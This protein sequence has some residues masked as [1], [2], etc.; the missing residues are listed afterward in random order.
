[1]RIVVMLVVALA[2]TPHV[3]RAQSADVPALI[4]LVD[5]EPAD[6]DRSV[7]K[8]KRREAVKKLA[9]SKDR[10]AVPVLIKLAETETFD[11]VG[12]IAIEGLGTL[13]DPSA[14]PTLQKI[15]GDPSRDKG[16]RDLARKSLAKLGASSAPT[17]APAPTPTPTPTPTPAPESPTPAPTAETGLENNVSDTT[18]SKLIDSGAPTPPPTASQLPQLD[19]DILAAYDRVTFAAGNASVTYE[20]IPGGQHQLEAEGS[21]SALWQQRVEHEQ[22]AWGFDGSASLVGGV[23][24]PPGRADSRGVELNVGGDG[25]GRAYW[26]G[27]YGVGRVAVDFDTDYT[28]DIVANPANANDYKLTTTDADGQ[29]ALGVGYGRELDVS[30][31]IRVR[32]LSRALDANRALGKPIDA[33]TSKKLQLTWWSLR[34]ERSAYRALLATVAILREAGVLLGEPDAGLT[35]EILNV[36]RD[37]YLYQRMDGFDANVEFGEGYLR[38]PADIVNDGFENGRVEQLL[39]NVGYGIQLDDDKMQLVATGY[40]RDRLFAP[41]NQ[42]SPW[43]LGASATA[44]RFTYGEH[45]DQFGALDLTATAQYAGGD[46]P[47]PMN[48]TAFE[49]ALQLGFTYLINQASGLRL[50]AQ[51]T[52][53]DGIY[54]FGATF[55]ATYGLLDGV[56]SR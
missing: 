13:G 41:M 3:A 46:L 23:I 39:V 38:R 56:F 51:V 35:Y 43:A 50:A 12:E 1:M 30:A 48:D 42:T 22:Y 36:L 21:A 29:L 27:F 9:E 40:A 15:V 28:A 11:I 10:R 18:G 26:H 49:L 52:E 2:L 47:A 32:R 5:N 34:A 24:N 8:E 6:M 45:G 25:E 53:D 54:T 44:T 4:K 33:A 55:T 37:T 31:Q 7:W 19:D 16:Q 20:P 14:V 17:P